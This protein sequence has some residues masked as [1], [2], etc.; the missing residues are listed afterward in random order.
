LNTQDSFAL[1]K[2]GLAP[3]PSQLGDGWDFEHSG[4]ATQ[5]SGFQFEEPAV[6][7]QPYR[8]EELPEHACKYVNLAYP[9]ANN[10]CESWILFLKVCCKPDTAVFII[11]TVWFAAISPRVANGFATVISVLLDRTSS[12]IWFVPST[13]K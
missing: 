11:R 5:Q 10:C 3:L 1:E 7:P 2:F 8:D 9:V 13:R 6:V 4:G 12:R